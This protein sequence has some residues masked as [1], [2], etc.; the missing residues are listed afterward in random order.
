MSKKPSPVVSVGIDVSQDHSDAC[1][2]DGDENVVHQGCYT[3]DKYI[4]LAKKIA[5]AKPRIAL[6]EASGSYERELAAVLMAAGVPLR[7]I[8]PSRTRQF[9]NAIGELSKTDAVDARMLALYALRNKVE[10]GAI[11]DERTVEIKALLNRRRQLI[12][13][14]TAEMNRLLGT[15]HKAM[16]KSIE[17]MLSALEEHIASVD[18]MLDEAIDKDDDFRSKEKLLTSVPGVGEQTARAL[19]GEMPELGKLNRREAASLAGLAPFARD[20][21]KQRGKRSIRGGRFWVRNSLYMAT[22]TA[23]RCNEP[24]RQIYQRLLANGKAKKVALTACMR[25]LLLLLNALLKKNEVFA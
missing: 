22:L 3:V 25:K 1:F 6:M 9:A 21:G 12:Q 11:P 18:A 20:S 10:P 16:R 23:V 5:K 19:L 4:A 17:E 14:R 24:I 13:L 15:R 2:L 7:I 8:N